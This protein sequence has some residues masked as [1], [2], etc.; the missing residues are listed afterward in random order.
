MQFK[1]SILKWI[2]HIFRTNK[3]IIE[4]IYEAHKLIYI[5]AILN[6]QYIN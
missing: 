5:Y 1:F 3:L 6:Y 2:F 4:D